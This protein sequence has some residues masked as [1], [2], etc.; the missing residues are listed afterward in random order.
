MCARP[1]VAR[2][3]RLASRRLRFFLAAHESFGGGGGVGGGWSIVDVFS[4]AILRLVIGTRLVDFG[5]WLV[6]WLIRLIGWSVQW[7]FGWFIWVIVI[8]WFVG[9]CFGFAVWLVD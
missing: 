3:L 2:L 9:W 6:G 7:L 8:G 5:C 4:P 1:C